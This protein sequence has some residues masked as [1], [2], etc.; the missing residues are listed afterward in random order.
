MAEIDVI[1]LLLCL[2]SIIAITICLLAIY[3]SYRKFRLRP[4]L[5]YFGAFFMFLV[6]VLGILPS[7]LIFDAS[8]ANF[9]TFSQAY[10]FGLTFFGLLFLYLGISTSKGSLP[11]IKTNLMFFM[12]GG[13]MLG[14]F[15][16]QFY[17]LTLD[18]L[19]NTWMVHYNPAFLVFIS[20]AML[21]LIIELISY[22]RLIIRSGTG[23]FFAFTY[24]IGWLVLASSGVVFF[25]SRIDAFVSYLAAN[26]YLA[27]FSFGVLIISF[28]IFINPSNLIASPLKVY[29]L[30][31]VDT[32]SGLPRFSYNFRKSELEVEPALFSGVITGI[33]LALK[34]TVKGNRY[35]KRIDGVDRK[36]LLER[37][38]ETQA[39]LTVEDE[40]ILFRRIL[41]R[42][43]I[44]FE[45][46]FYPLLGTEDKVIDSDLYKGFGEKV[47][48]YFAF[49]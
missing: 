35:L 3:L 37:G 2:I 49:A 40:T 7:T 9:I 29:Y 48:V 33:S 18:T 31:F 15:N 1:N 45:M 30:S 8:Q 14:Y 26:L 42:L 43:L 16:P 10:T 21:I 34:E 47:K 5:F 28:I 41:K 36:I 19:T 23:K 4:I 38:L 6:G 25:L 11:L 44:L 22:A 39:V 24:F 27:F 12:V 13:T 32:E 17:H 46:E 20:F